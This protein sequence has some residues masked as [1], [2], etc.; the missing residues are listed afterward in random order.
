VS[1]ALVAITAVDLIA[2]GSG[3]ALNTG[4]AI[5]HPLVTPQEF[6][7]TAETPAKLNKLVRQTVQAWRVEG[8][9]DSRQWA[10]TAGVSEIPT[11]HGN[12]PLFQARVLAVRRIFCEAPWWERYCEAA[13]LQSP[14][15]DLLSVRYVLAWEPGNPPEVQKV[16]LR[17]VEQTPGHFVYERPHALP[18]FFLVN[19]V[20]ITKDVDE[21]VAAL[22]APDFDPRQVAVVEGLHGWDDSDGPPP[23]FGAVKV[24]GY[25][26]RYVRL[27]V[28]APTAAFLVTS[29]THYPGWKA[30]LDGQEQT[31]WMANGAFRGLVVPA[32]RHR[33]E[34][35]FAPSIL[36][37][38]L[39][40]SILA[41]SGL[42]WALLR[43]RPS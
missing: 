27:E 38:S 37:Y 2:V 28:D 8:V 25:G 30:L 6:E 12:D 3:Q 10:S 21:S 34:M 22:R 16:G 31:L 18:R 26:M 43:N 41:W 32:G 42:L 35:H 9:R 13:A 23:D 29:E 40:V 24:Q 20:R 39:A 11:P 1:V 36:W 7:G 17:A 19:R 33:I 5:D 4:K 14:I 15:L